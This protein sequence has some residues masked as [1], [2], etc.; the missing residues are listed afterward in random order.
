MG[1]LGELYTGGITLV[2]LNNI[3]HVKQRKCEP[4]KTLKMRFVKYKYQSGEFVAQLDKRPGYRRFAPAS[5]S[6]MCYQG[7][8]EALNATGSACGMKVLITRNKF[9][10]ALIQ[11]YHAVMT[12]K[13]LRVVCSQFKTNSSFGQ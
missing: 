7:L 6:K 5:R 4:G 8:C 10:I 3:T 13:Y 12:V 2:F 1:Y 9:I 11:V